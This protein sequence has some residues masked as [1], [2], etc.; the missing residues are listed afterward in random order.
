MWPLGGPHGI[1]LAATAE[2]GVL[3]AL[4]CGRSWGLLVVSETGEERSFPIWG[5]AE[6]VGL[7]TSGQRLLL[8]WCDDSGGRL[9]SEVDLTDGRMVALTRLTPTG[10]HDGPRSHR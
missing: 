7:R 3:V 6:L 4:R 9:R 10:S 2:G 5:G 1:A 8:E